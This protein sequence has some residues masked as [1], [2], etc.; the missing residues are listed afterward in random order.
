MFYWP[1]I[2][3]GAKLTVQLSKQITNDCI[4]DKWL[5]ISLCEHHSIKLKNVKEKMPCL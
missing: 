4:E 2:L 3:S 5:S 1:A